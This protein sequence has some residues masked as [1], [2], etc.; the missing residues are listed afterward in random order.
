M[1]LV[2]RVV[3][4]SSLDLMELV[5]AV[6]LALLIVAPI[7]YIAFYRVVNFLIAAAG[8]RTPVP[9]SIAGAIFVTA[10]FTAVWSAFRVVEWHYT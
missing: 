10:V 3:N 5:G 7:V 2:D 4:Q 9:L 8:V 1:R 6:L